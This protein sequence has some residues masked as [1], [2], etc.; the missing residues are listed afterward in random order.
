MTPSK[1]LEHADMPTHQEHRSSKRVPLIQPCPYELSR[2]PGGGGVELSQGFAL[3]VNISSG[4][5]LLLMP[6]APGERQ[7]F[8][9]QELSL[10]T[11]AKRSTKLL[12]VCWTRQLPMGAEG[13]MHSVGVRFLF[14]VPT[15]Q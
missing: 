15:S 4:G 2:V 5:M 13:S 8:E 11:Q 3:T 10:R 6:Q 7:I 9:V 14:E 12:E 1:L